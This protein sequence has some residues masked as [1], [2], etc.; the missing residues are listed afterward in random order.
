MTRISRTSNIDLL[1]NVERTQSG[2]VTKGEQK[3]SKKS[4]IQ[5]FS[6][7]KQT[8]SLMIKD[9]QEPLEKLKPQIIREIIKFQFSETNFTNVQFKAAYDKLLKETENSDVYQN[10]INTF[11]EE[12]RE[13]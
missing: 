12:Q 1:H 13:R 4:A 10:I 7:L 11:I 2:N 6:H 3:P 8:V 9:S 5:D